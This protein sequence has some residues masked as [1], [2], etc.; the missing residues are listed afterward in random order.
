[1]ME[2]QTLSPTTKLGRLAR[3]PLK[4]VPPTMVMPV[5]T[6][7]LRGKRWIVGSGIHGCWLGW[8]ES[9]KQRVI[10]KEVRPNTVFYDVGANVGFYSLLAAV[11]V[12]PGKVFSFEPLPRNISY[13]KRH[14]ALNHASNVDVQELAISDKNSAAKF[15]VEKTG[16]MGHL[17]SEGEI[18]VPTAT[19][20]SLLQEGR[21]LP[22]NYIKMDIEGAE[23]EALL[24]ARECFER[25]RPTLFLATHGR[26]VHEQC[27]GLLKSWGYELSLI[28]TNGEELLAVP[29]AR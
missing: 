25:Y 20:D 17:A 23:H 29:R 4:L 10:S 1:M 22:P 5:L 24:G 11:L 6:G 3:Y 12:G 28:G 2:S 13:L 9:E 14:L 27:C 15:S 7:K 21:I 16:Y 18:T 26:D 19:L 8:Y